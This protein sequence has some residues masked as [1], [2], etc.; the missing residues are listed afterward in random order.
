MGSRIWDGV[1]PEEE[2]ALHVR[3]QGAIER[4]PRV[5]ERAA[6]IVVDMSRE[7]VDSAYPTGDSAAGQPAVEATLPLLE[8]ARGA[9]IPIVFT[10]QLMQERINAGLLGPRRYEIDGE[11]PRTD[12]S[13]PD[14]SAVADAFAPREEEL[15]LLKTKPSGFHATPLQ[16][17]LTAARVDTLL[18]T[19]MVT[20]GC[21]RATVLDGFMNNY[22][23][24][25]PE[26][27]TADWS[28][29]QHATSLFDMHMKYAD[30][31]STATAISLLG[32]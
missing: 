31:V 21:V 5:G 8:A 30:V 19:G 18:I 20:S 29:F 2:I 32:R 3:R 28:P 6:L 16:E 17:F 22:N 25:V 1:V 24:I 15:Q 4:E 13:L 23:V 26:E 10:R 9:G 11:A 14:G 27:C 12:P 7:F